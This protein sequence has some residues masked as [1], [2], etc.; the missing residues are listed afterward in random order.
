MYWFIRVRLY[1]GLTGFPAYSSI[2][3]FVSLYMFDVLFDGNKWMNE[4]MNE[5]ICL[6]RA[7]CFVINSSCSSVILFSSEI[8]RG[9]VAVVAPSIGDCIKRDSLQTDQYNGLE[10]VNR[11]GP[12]WQLFCVFSNF[13]NMLYVMH[14]HK[15][16]NKWHLGKKKND[17]YD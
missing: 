5:W 2:R 1:S 12:N 14:S 7:A 3:F 9:F 6:V 8:F 10:S 11:S 16:G 13:E 15:T 4:W 17:W